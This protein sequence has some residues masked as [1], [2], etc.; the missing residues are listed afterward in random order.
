MEKLPVSVFI[1]AKDE[2]DR[3]P[4]TIESV[5][6][7]VDEVIV[8]DSGSTDDT[9]AVAE[10]LGARVEFNE[11]KGYGPQ[12]VRGELLCRNDWLLNLDADEAITPALRDEIAALFVAGAP[13]APLYRIKVTTVYPHH[14]KPRFLAEYK[15][16]VRLYDRRVARFP[17]HPTW[18]AIVPPAGAAVGQLRAP[19]LHFTWRSVGH[20]MDKINSYS[21]MQAEHQPLK[22]F[23]FLIVQLVFGP[24]LDFL[25]AYLWRR[26]FTGGSFGFIVS[27]MF[28]ISR[29]LKTAKM[30]ER[31]LKLR[32]GRRR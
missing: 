2:A 14:R 31:H 20:Y 12:K 8:V 6:G 11:W 3:I 19:C 4:Q 29:F 32:A 7:W 17:D 25:K 26:H 13:P 22:P 16:I 28:V 18:D 27:G 21:S 15:N 5:R 30:I 10:A 23:W 9:V 1:I 24:P